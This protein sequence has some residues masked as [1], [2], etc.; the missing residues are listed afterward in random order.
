MLISTHF[1]YFFLVVQNICTI[2]AVSIRQA[3]KFGYNK[4]KRLKVQA[5]SSV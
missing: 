1:L 3:S 2:F 5:A 4:N